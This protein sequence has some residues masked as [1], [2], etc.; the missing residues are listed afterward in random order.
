MGYVIASNHVTVDRKPIGYCYRERPDS[1]EDSGWR[2]F[3]GDESQ[4]YADDPA[5]F[6]MVNASTIVRLDPSITPVLT[7]LYPIAFERDEAT[8]DFVELE[9]EDRPRF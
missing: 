5:N 1:D 2:V 9:S 7:R 6:S 8:G 4:A 3:S